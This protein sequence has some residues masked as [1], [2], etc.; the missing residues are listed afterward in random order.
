MRLRVFRKST[1]GALTGGKTAPHE[2]AG[3][4][5]GGT[6]VRNADPTRIAQ[7]DLVRIW[8]ASINLLE[9]AS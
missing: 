6:V 1:A 4:G 7:G 2:T 5:T 3:E 9:I 8:I